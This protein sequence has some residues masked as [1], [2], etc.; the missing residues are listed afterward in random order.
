MRK[1]N[2]LRQK[3][4]RLVFPLILLVST[5]SFAATPAAPAADVS[6]ANGQPVSSQSVGRN[7]A[8][9]RQQ[10]ASK[11]PG[12]SGA[13]TAARVYLDDY[14]RLPQSVNRHYPTKPHWL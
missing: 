4:R 12:S 10:S 2:H 3:G 8:I 11:T 14:Q 9:T 1:F 6:Q 7:E 5:S 13:A